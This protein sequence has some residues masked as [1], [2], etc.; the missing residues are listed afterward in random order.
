MAKCKIYDIKRLI[1][2]KKLKLLNNKELYKQTHLVHNITACIA[3][4]KKSVG[5]CK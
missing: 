2:N 1:N 5:K 3:R 4:S